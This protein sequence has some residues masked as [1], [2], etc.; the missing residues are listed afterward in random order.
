[1]RVAVIGATGVVGGTIL[2]VLEERSVPVDTL[3]AYASRERADGVTFRGASLPVAA[4]TRERLL[5]DRGVVAEG[6][7]EFFTPGRFSVTGAGV[8]CGFSNGLPVIDEISPPFRF[9]GI[10]DSLFVEVDGEPHLRRHQARVRGMV[11]A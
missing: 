2:R 5:A 9:S 3:L 10:I 8:T 1:M 4:T 7:I 6:T 11:G